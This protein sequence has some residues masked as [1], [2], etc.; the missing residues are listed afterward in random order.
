MLWS[1][2]SLKSCSKQLIYKWLPSQWFIFKFRT[3]DLC[4]CVRVFIQHLSNPLAVLQNENSLFQ[5]P[6]PQIV[7]FLKSSY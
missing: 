5:K 6:N 4:V 2:V 1:I 3:T 7:I